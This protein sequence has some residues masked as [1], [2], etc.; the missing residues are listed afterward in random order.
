MLPWS[1]AAM[2]PPIPRMVARSLPPL[3]SSFS[4]NS[5]ADKALT[6]RHLDELQMLGARHAILGSPSGWILIAVGFPVALV[7]SLIARIRKG[8]DD[9]DKRSLIRDAQIGRAH[10]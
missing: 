5:W 7:A 1:S 8:R 10:V 9:D 2:R 6:E 4:T 3:A